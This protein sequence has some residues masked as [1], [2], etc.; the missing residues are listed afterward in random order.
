M[1][2][3][4]PRWPHLTSQEIDDISALVPIGS[5]AGDRYAEVQMTKFLYE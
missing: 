1:T 2:K 4:L 3:T 5:A